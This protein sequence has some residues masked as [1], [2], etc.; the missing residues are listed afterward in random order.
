[1][2]E[3]RYELVSLPT[4]CNEHFRRVSMHGTR[5]ELLERQA[6][7]IGLPL[8]KMFVGQRS[9]NAEY[10]ENLTRHLFANK[11]RGVSSCVFGD[12]FLEDLRRWREEK[13]AKV[14]LAGVFPIWKRIPESSLANSWRKVSD[15]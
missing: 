6:E 13:L 11:A 8:E 3:G 5:I 2:Q 1:M 4:T 15:R 10:L 7:A 12:F 9:S 14:G